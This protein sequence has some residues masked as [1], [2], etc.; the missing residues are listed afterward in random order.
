MPS[1]PTWPF[2][3]EIDR[4]FSIEKYPHQL[5]FDVIEVIALQVQTR[6]QHTA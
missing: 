2:D 6:N 4:F 1:K 5:F 3:Q